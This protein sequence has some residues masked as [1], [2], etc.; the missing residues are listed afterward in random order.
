MGVMHNDKSDLPAHVREAVGRELAAQVEKTSQTAVA[1]WLGVSQQAVQ[2]AVA[3]HRVGGH[4]AG[5]LCEKLG[6]TLDDLC[7][8]W[9]AKSPE[10]RERAWLRAATVALGT[11]VE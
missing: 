11:V 8:K 1:R 6:C 5:A 4:V 10:E 9:G 2:R 3:S 7:R